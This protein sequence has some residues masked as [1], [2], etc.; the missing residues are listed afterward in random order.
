MNA[1]TGF[2]A[3]VLTALPASQL[4][5]TVF[6]L[7]GDRATL[8]ELGPILKTPV[9]HADKVPGP[10]GE[11]S[12]YIQANLLEAGFGSTGWD[13]SRG[14]EGTD[15]AGSTNDLW[16]GHRWKTIREVLNI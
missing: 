15:K 11:H 2:V 12:T 14:Q 1:T 13:A 5:N 8:L 16:E 10:G 3:H 9:E 6:R 4:D 7:Q